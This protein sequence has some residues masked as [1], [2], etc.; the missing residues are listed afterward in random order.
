[1][2]Q[3]RGTQLC[4]KLFP[5]LLIYLAI[6]GNIIQKISKF[7]FGNDLMIGFLRQAENFSNITFAK[8]GPRFSIVHA[9][10]LLS[11][12]VKGPPHFFCYLERHAKT[13]NC[14]QT[15][16]QRKVTGRKMKKK[17]KEK[18][19][20][21]TPSLVATSSTSARTTFVC[22]HSTR[23]NQNQ[24]QE[25]WVTNCGLAENINLKNPEKKIGDLGHG[26][27]IHL[28]IF[29]Y[30]KIKLNRTQN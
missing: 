29:C 1:M 21:I 30:F 9:L 26:N 12:Q 16:S 11:T 10:R 6:F 25:Q 14:R 22:M 3:L 5:L 19:R 28:L 15:P 13:Q 23:T 7:Q 17:E 8:G 4:L 27:R 2:I 20:R 18:R 24:E